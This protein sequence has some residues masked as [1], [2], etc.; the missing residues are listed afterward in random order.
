M[1]VMMRDR[2]VLTFD[3]MHFTIGMGE[4]SPDMV[5]S[6]PLLSA[7]QRYFKYNAGFR[8]FYVQWEISVDFPAVDSWGI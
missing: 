2:F 8:L 4:K 5:H 1:R 6:A 3:D 7:R